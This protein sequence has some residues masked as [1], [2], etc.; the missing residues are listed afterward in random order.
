MTRMAGRL[1]T[2]Q[3]ELDRRI[4]S[5]QNQLAAVEREDASS[6]SDSGL[7]D[8]MAELE[9]L[10]QQVAFANILA[11]LLLNAYGTLLGKRVSS[12]GLDPH[13]VDL[14][15]GHPGLVDYD[16]T[17]HLG[18]IAAEFARLDEDTQAAV[19]GG[20]LDALP[21]A[22]WFLERFGHLSDSGNDFS[23]VPWREDPSQLAPLLQVPPSR[24]STR[25][26]VGEV[27]PSLP[28][29]DRAL[30][31]KAQ[32]FRWERERVSY[33]YSRGY[34]LFRPTVLEIAS[35]ESN[36]DLCEVTSNLQSCHFFPANHAR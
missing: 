5:L 12:R 16:P 4:P 21:G 1:I 30:A 32:R 29:P 17:P 23:R 31:R 28:Q 11:P 10:V 2:Y 20:D 27:L 8:R 14:T 15:G 9:Q 3:R 7:V 34:G 35:P 26:D 13:D 33:T 25:G 36:P 24:G 18:R 22:D 19:I 6:L